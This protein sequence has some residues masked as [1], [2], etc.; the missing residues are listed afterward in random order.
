MVEMAPLKL[1]NAVRTALQ[2]TTSF[3]VVSFSSGLT[4]G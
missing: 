1:P 4:P 3:I 2:I